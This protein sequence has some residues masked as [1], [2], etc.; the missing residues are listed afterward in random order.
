MSEYYQPNG[1]SYNYVPVGSLVNNAPSSASCIS[2]HERTA[3]GA[4]SS[5]GG[6]CGYGFQGSCHV[7]LPHVQPACCSGGA[8]QC[9]CGSDKQGGYQTLQS[10]YGNS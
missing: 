1:G 9:S 3:R 10:G 8:P 4:S 6:I 2:C 7:S 5:H